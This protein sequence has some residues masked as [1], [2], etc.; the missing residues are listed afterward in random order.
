MTWFVNTFEDKPT[1]EAFARYGGEI[2]FDDIDEYLEDDIE[3]LSTADR[4]VPLQGW[5]D[6]R[7][8]IHKA[9]D[10]YRREKIIEALPIA[11]QQYRVTI[12]NIKIE[13]LDYLN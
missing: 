9:A 13:F 3:L 1:Q 6:W 4:I 11:Y 10:A 7:E 8:A 5:F 2:I 12:A